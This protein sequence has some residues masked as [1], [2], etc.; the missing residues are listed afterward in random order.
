MAKAY[1]QGFGLVET[2]NASDPKVTGTDLNAVLNGYQETVEQI[3]SRDD[4]LDGPKNR[5]IQQAK[6]DYL[7]RF[8]QTVQNRQDEIDTRRRMAYRRANPIVPEDVINSP[9]RQEV[10]GQLAEG[11]SAAQL[12]EQ[13][14]LQ[15]HDE[16]LKVL[17]YEGPLHA[18]DGADLMDLLDQDYPERIEAR[19]ELKAVEED[20]MSNGAA[21]ALLTQNFQRQLFAEDGVED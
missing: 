7:E 12:Y 17:R 2:D 6:D 5:M 16:A 4:I 18:D 10:L 8:N 3:K 11:R 20:D 19:Q 15:G 21:V 13:Y 9:Y 1:I 14:K